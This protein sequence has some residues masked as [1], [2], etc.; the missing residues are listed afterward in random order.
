GCGNRIAA[1]DFLTDLFEKRLVIAVKAHITV[2]VVKNQQITEASQPVRVNDS[3]AGHCFDI[4]ARLAANEQT[5][6]GQTAVLPLS[7]KP[8]RQF[9]DYRPSQLASQLPECP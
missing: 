1:P 7:A 9:P 8:I 4:P 6:P 5:L 3:S 2:A